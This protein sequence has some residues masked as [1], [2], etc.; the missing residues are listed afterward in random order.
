M[1]TRLTLDALLG[2]VPASCRRVWFGDR[3]AVTVL[4]GAIRDSFT[5]INAM[6][7]IPW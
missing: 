1:A 6:R 4:G 7:Q 3:G 2:R 5:E